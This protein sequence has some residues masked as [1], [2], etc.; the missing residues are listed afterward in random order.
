MVENKKIINA[1]KLAEFFGLE[2]EF[3]KKSSKFL[4]TQAELNKSDFNKKFRLWESSLK[5]IY[6]REIEQ[7][8]FLKHSYYASILNELIFLKTNF[9]VDKTL[10]NHFDLN[11]LNFY[12][13]PKFDKELQSEIK[14]WIFTAI[15][16]GMYF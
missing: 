13:C 15:F 11:E 3:Y 5:K 7:S 6:G 10:Y 2:T 9:S 14:S 1:N 16:S 4:K 8:L 12:F